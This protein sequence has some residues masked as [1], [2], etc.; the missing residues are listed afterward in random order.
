MCQ[1]KRHISVWSLNDTSYCNRFPKII[2]LGPQKTGTTALY[3]FLN[4][5]PLLESNKFTHEN[6]EETQFFSNKNYFKGIDW[7]LKLFNNPINDS[8]ILFEKSANYFT[9]NKAP[10]RIKNLLKSPK[11]VII[12]INPVDRAYSWYQVCIFCYFHYYN[13]C[14]VNNFSKINQK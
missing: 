2:I 12:T 10:L 11:F 6:F 3:T 5:H 4:E 8:I 13:D 7:Y 1:D 9:E 14:L